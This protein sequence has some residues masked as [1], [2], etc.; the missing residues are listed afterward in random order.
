[1]DM[2]HSAEIP[3]IVYKGL[4]VLLDGYLLLKANWI[5]LLLQLLCE[6]C[7]ALQR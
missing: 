2:F 4:Y 3:N 6:L 7:D 1:M 5:A